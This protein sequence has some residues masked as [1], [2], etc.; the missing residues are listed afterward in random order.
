[1]GKEL[2][3]SKSTDTIQQTILTIAKRNLLLST[4]AI[5]T[6]FCFMFSL[7][8]QT[9]LLSRSD[10]LE[11]QW[12]RD[13]QWAFCQFDQLVNTCTCLLIFPKVWA[14]PT[15][16]KTLKLIV[17]AVSFNGKTQIV[18]QSHVVT[19]SNESGTKKII[20]QSQVVN[21]EEPLD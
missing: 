9:S 20:P 18:P 12:W 14:S 4:L 7:S 17:S 21:A 10:D 1:M 3:E 8:L 15:T 6:T 11:N 13:Y 19:L 5:L 2:Y 16:R